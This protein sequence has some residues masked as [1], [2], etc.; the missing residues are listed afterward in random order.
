MTTFLLVPACILRPPLMSDTQIDE[1]NTTWSQT[2][3][4]IGSTTCSSMRQN[5][6]KMESTSICKQAEKNIVYMCQ[7]EHFRFKQTEFASNN[8]QSNGQ[9]DP[10]CPTGLTGEMLNTLQNTRTSCKTSFVSERA[11]ANMLT[12]KTYYHHSTYSMYQV[13]I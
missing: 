1:A 6:Y 10:D 7:G 13:P 9:A 5:H 8:A 11:T 2:L 12:C 4:Y 3:L